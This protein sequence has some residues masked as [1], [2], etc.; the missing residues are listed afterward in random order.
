MSNFDFSILYLLQDDL[1]LNTSCWDPNLQI[2]RC[3]PIPSSADCNL[4]A[5]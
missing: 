3:G 5:L 1:E 2:H 4:Y